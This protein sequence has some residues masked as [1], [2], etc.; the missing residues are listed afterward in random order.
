MR[1]GRRPPP[2]RCQ[3]GGG[4]QQDDGADA[5][6]HAGEFEPAV[7]RPVE[8]VEVEGFLAGPAGHAAEGQ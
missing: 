5:A 6:V 4:G 8:D 1:S 3:A 2:D 7:D